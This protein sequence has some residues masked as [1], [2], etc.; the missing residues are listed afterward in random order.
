MAH[1][2]RHPVKP[3]TA[4]LLLLAAPIPL[5]RS[6]DGDPAAKIY[7]DTSKSVFLLQVKSEAGDVVA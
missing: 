1:S 7:A 6:Q 4:W 5:L 2:I 3:S